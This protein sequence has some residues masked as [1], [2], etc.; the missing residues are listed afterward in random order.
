M[1]T[2]GYIN[3]DT[4][5]KRNQKGVYTIVMRLFLIK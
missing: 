4:Y 3:N 1:F 2:I 5:N